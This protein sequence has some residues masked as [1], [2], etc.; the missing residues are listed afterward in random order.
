MVAPAPSP[1]QRILEPLV[2]CLTPESA[3]QLLG[4]RLDDPT[5]ARL[6]ELAEKSN[7]GTITEPER[8]E[9]LQFVEL[10]DMVGILQA[11]ARKLLQHTATHD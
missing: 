9:Y 2:E 10:I 6:D 11:K 8:D 3:R 5:Q 7:Q 1:M 4:F